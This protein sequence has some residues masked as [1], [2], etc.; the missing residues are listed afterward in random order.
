MENHPLTPM[1]D[2]NLVRV[3]SHQTEGTVGLVPFVTVDQGVHAI[4]DAMTQLKERGGAMRSSTPSPTR[5]WFRLARR[6]RA[7]R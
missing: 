5:I 3:L 6:R 4:R 2:A 7:M 1:T